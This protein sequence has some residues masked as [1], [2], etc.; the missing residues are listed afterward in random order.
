MIKSLVLGLAMLAVPVCAG[1][2]DPPKLRIGDAAPTALGVD[3]QGD[4][5][6]LSRYRGKVVVLSFWASWCGPCRKELP[7]LEA[8]QKTYARFD[9]L[10]VVAVN[11][12][13]DKNDYRVMLK[14]MKDFTMLHARDN[15][16]T[17]QLD[18]GV[19]AVPNL[20]IIDEQG[21]VV[22]RHSGYGENSLEAIVADVQSVLLEY[23]KRRDAA[24]SAAPAAG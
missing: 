7:A 19:R 22:K 8:I 21:R 12:D 1:A 20:W 9:V 4:A 14:Q 18:Y 10:Q 13:E 2:A 6:D 23:V 17:V 11:I 3:R 5:V 24:K 16:G 15:R